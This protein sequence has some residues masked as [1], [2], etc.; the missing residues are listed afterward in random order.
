MR[1]RLNASLFVAIERYSRALSSHLMPTMFKTTK[2]LH[3]LLEHILQL[4]RPSLRG[5]TTDAVQQ[6]LLQYLGFADR[7]AN[8]NFIYRQGEGSKTLFMCHYDTVETR[9]GKNRLS[10]DRQNMIVR[11]AGG[12]I[13]GADCGAGMY[14]LIRM[15]QAGVPGTYVFFNDEEAG[16]I[17]STEY[18]ILE[19]APTG[20]VRAIAFDRKGYTDVVTHQ[21][22][23]AGC[24]L[25]F[26]DALSTALNV[27]IPGVTQY[28]PTDKGSFTDSYSFFDCIH[29]CTNISVGYFNE[30]Q[31]SEYLD[32][33]FLQRLL[34][35]LLQLD[36]EALPTTRLLP[37][38][39][40]RFTLD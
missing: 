30:H 32:Y 25:N 19:G 1:I 5:S 9:T 35:G 12:G 8:G 11:V 29:E 15:L 28:A 23:Q 34:A 33:G 17:G 40:A 16:R 2:A 20:C 39:L 26:A 6:L 27:H 22:M 18:R 3:P 21:L 4:K 31:Q 36:F 37:R 13:L 10:Y 14:L 38:R 24:S 7:D